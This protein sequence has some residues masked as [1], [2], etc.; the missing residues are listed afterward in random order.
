MT[1]S[2]DLFSSFEASPT[3]HIL[4]GNN[5][6]MTICGKGSIDIDD[7]TFHDVL[8]SIFVLSPSLYLSNYTQSEREDSGAFT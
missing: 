5:T 6:V 8:C 7:C 2:Q 1:S 4:M 3:P